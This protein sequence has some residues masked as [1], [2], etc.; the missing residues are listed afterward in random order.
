MKKPQKLANDLKKQIEHKIWLSGEKLPSIRATCKRYKLSIETVLQAYQLLENQGYIQAKPKSGYY[1]MPQR[2]IHIGDDKVK[3]LEP[4]PVKISDLLYDVLHRAKD[5]SIIPL[6]SAFPD[7]ALF[8][9]QALSRSLANASRQMPSNSM[10]TNLPPGSESLRRQIAQRYQQRGLNVLPEEIVITSGAMEALNLSLQACTKPGDRVAIE[11]PAFYGVLQ[12]LERLN[13][14]AVEIPT[15]PESGL[16]LD[17]LE[18]ALK[19]MDIKACWFMTYAQNPVGYSLTDKQK[20]RLAE[21]MQQYKTPMIEDDVYGEL[22]AGTTPPLPAKAYDKGNQI[23]LCGSFSKSLSPGFRIGWVVAGDKTLTIQRLQHL[24]TLSTSIPIQLG[25]SHYLT[26]YSYD[27]H[28]RKIRRT[29]AARKADHIACL[30]KHL[31][32]GVKIHGRKGGYFLWV[33]L[34]PS[35]DVEVLYEKGIEENLSIAPGIIFSSDKKFSHHIRINTSYE[36]EENIRAGIESLG[37]IVQALQDPK[38]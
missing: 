25:L 14:E 21:L 22:Y 28:L 37:Q 19:S 36:C 3:K 32:E 27:N 13:L 4:F 26:Y 24:S 12:A 8:P 1:V 15:D 20:Q 9:H 5:P 33:E 35:I 2:G 10:L 6:S 31:P 34:D 23:L 11:Y 18:S 17:V 7:P 29:L 30:E 38:C 16:D